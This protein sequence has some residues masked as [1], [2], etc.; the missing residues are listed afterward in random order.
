MNIVI[1]L[2]QMGNKQNLASQQVNAFSFAPRPFN[3]PFILIV[4]DLI[5]LPNMSCIGSRFSQ[6][7]V[8]SVCRWLVDIMVSKSWSNE[9]GPICIIFAPKFSLQSRHHSHYQR[10][11]YHCLHTIESSYLKIGSC[12][13]HN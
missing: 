4:Q 1:R 2:K 6:P 11:Y 3:C 8:S 12:N 7:Y 10:V 13:K 9:R 5:N